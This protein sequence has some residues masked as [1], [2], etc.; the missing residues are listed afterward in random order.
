MML[1]ML[2]QIVFV[3]IKDSLSFITLDKAQDPKTL[4]LQA[5]FTSAL[6]KEA[7]AIS[8]ALWMAEAMMVMK[9]ADSVLTIFSSPF[10]S[11]WRG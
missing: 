6:D 5:D 4:F 3:L 7:T 2:L 1:A 11:C 10:G 9:K 8:H